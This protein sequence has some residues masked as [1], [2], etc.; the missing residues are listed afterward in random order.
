MTPLEKAIEAYLCQQ[1]V[2]ERDENGPPDDECESEARHIVRMVIEAAAKD[3]EYLYFDQDAPQIEQCE[4]IC[5]RIR[6]LASP[7]PEKESEP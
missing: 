1:F 3:I 5:E 2:C 7:E 4:L 6:A